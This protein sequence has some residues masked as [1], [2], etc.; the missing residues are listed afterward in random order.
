VLA[1]FV[2]LMLMARFQV[3]YSRPMSLLLGA[4]GLGARG[5]WVEV[6]GAAVEA[7]LGWAFRARFPHSSVKPAT[8][9]DQRVISRGVHGRN[10]R[11]LV[12]G[13][14]TGLVRIDLVPQQEARVLGSRVALSTLLVSMEDPDALLAALSIASEHDA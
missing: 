12:N 9:S 7:R 3:A 6:E 4:L 8:R 10:G 14:A 1:E 13:A 5:A 11:W 2:E